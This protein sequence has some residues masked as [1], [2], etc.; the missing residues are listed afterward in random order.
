MYLNVRTNTITLSEENIEVNNSEFV[1]KK[2]FLYD[3]K[4]TRD[5]YKIQKSIPFTLE[6]K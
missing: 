6:S 3:T 2:A 4:H 1:F 5:E